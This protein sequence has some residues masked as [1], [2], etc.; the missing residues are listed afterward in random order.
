[1]IVVSMLAKEKKKKKKPIMGSL[2][3]LLS[4]QSIRI[5]KESKKEVGTRDHMNIVAT[6]THYVLIWGHQLFVIILQS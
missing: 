2:L 3:S 4:P 1:M 6:F 5:N